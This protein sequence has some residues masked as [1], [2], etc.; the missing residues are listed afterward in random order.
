MD[1]VYLISSAGEIAL[2]LIGAVKIGGLTPYD[3]ERAIE[4]ASSTRDVFRS[5]PV[6]FRLTP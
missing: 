2:P 5:P 4:A 6:D 1:G 3:A